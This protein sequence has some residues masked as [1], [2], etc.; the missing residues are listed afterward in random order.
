MTDQ[1]L[2]PDPCPFCGAKYDNDVAISAHGRWVQVEC[3]ACHAMG[4]DV[5]TNAGSPTK[6]HIALAIQ[7]WNNLDGRR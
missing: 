3:M 2:L 1:E 7:K 4:P 5:K 6:E